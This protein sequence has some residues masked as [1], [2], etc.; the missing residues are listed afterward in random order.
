MLEQTCL[1]NN[2]FWRISLFFSTGR[3]DLNPM[4]TGNSTK[5]IVLSV[6]LLHPYQIFTQI[7]G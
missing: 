1:L 2:L 4:H 7:R 5:V 3:L 6:S